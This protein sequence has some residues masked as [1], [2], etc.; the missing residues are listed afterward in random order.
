VLPDAHSQIVGFRYFN[1]YGP[2]EAHKGPMASM[3]L[4][5]DDQLQ[6]TGKARLFGASPG[7]G[8]GEQ[9]RDFVYVRDVVD[10]ALWFLEHPDCSGIFNCG[11]GTT[12]TFRELAEEVIRFRGSG[13][14]EFIPFPDSLQG[15]YQG[16]TQADLQNLRSVGYTKD[17]ATLEQG[18]PEYLTWRRE[19]EGS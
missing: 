14:I 1:V 6:S 11:T 9:R 2:R 18:I 12:R 3:V 17:F 13:Q 7:Y 16:Y 19:N 4:Q 15:K 10:V 5:L 8:A